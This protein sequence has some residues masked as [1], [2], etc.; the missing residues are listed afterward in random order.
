MGKALMVT[1]SSLAGVEEIKSLSGVDIR[2]EEREGDQDG[3]VRRHGTHLHQQ[4][5]QKY[6]YRWNDSHG[7]LTGNWHK[8]SYT[9]KAARKIP[10]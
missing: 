5:Q 9:A 6:I 1:M 4:T 2:Q 10:M 8:N 7:K 3:G